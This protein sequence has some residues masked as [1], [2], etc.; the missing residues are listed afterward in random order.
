MTNDQR[1]MPNSPNPAPRSCAKARRGNPT[2]CSKSRW[3]IVSSRGDTQWIHNAQS[4]TAPSHN[5]PAP[6]CAGLPTP[7]TA[8]RRSPLQQSPLPNSL[9]PDPC[10]K[11]IFIPFWNT[12]V[13]ADTRF[14]MIYPSRLFRNHR[15]MEL[16]IE[17]EPNGF[18][19]EDRRGLRERRLI[20]RTEM[21][22][23]DGSAAIVATTVSA[24]KNAGFAG[25]SSQKNR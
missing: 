7:H 8:D 24:P 18:R 14:P 11:P 17:C 3:R 5:E 2:Y 13:R 23:L 4:P 15:L 9:L 10:F 21:T 19:T 1:L 16:K 6:L 22:T 20:S 25:N 12:H